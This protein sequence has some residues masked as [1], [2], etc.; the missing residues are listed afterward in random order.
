MKKQKIYYVSA[1][2]S[3]PTKYKYIEEIPEDVY[4]IMK[5]KCG[6]SSY[7]ENGNFEKQWLNTANG[8]NRLR[9]FI[10]SGATVFY[11]GEKQRIYR[12]GHRGPINQVLEFAKSE[13]NRETFFLGIKRAPFNVLKL[14]SDSENRMQ[15]INKRELN[16]LH[17]IVKTRYLKDKNESPNLENRNPTELNQSEIILE[18]NLMLSTIVGLNGYIASEQL[19]DLLTHSWKLT[20]FMDKKIPVKKIVIG[21]SS[22]SQIIKSGPG[23][24]IIDACREYRNFPSNGVTVYLNR[25]NKRKL[26]NLNSELVKNIKKTVAKLRKEEATVSFS[27]KQM[28]KEMEKAFAKMNEPPIREEI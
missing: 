21:T 12:P 1:H 14:Q 19:E 24:Y 23:I 5:A 20:N 4:I 18:I 11:N 8:A 27:A 28:E 2:S 9:E 22:I 7:V 26:E 16:A 15:R 17:T 13:T 25:N 3:I 10:K 6:V